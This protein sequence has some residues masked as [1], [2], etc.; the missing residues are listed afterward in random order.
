ML[1][2]LRRVAD[3]RRQAGGDYGWLFNPYTGDELVA[4]DCET[5]GIDPR[6]A[7]LVSIAA[8]KVRGDRVLTS[9]S[10]DLRLQP[11]ASLTGD[12]ICI[13]GLRGVD[14]AGG[15][16]VREALIKLLDFVGNRPLLGWRIEFDLLVINRH[17]RPLLG[18]DLPNSVI[19]VEHRYV[20]D[21]RRSHPVIDP[22]LSFESV[23]DA[24]Q[25]PVM[26]RHTAL[27]D[28][29]TTALMHVRMQKRLRPSA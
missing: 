16:S 17:L 28:A 13:H 1:R 3:R 6:N 5:T 10:L 29:V 4:I 27:G 18:F 25:V 19:D 15:D 11:P 26:G 22:C 7:E 2:T 14:L 21:L 12:S 23:A 20:R 24:L 9:D 8:V